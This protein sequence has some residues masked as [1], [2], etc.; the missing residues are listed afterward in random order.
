MYTPSV[1]KLI[2]QICKLP[3]IGEKTAERL[4]FYMLVEPQQALRLSEA[5]AQMVHQTRH[6]KVCYHFAEEELC[7]IC[8]D[9]T[10]DKSLICV[11]EEPKDVISVERSGGYRGLYHVLLGRFAPLEGK[12][13]ED[14]TINALRQ[15][16][17]NNPQIQEV[18]LATN[19]NLEGDG[20][21][22]YVAQMLQD[23]SVKITRIARGISWGLTLTH[24][25]KASMKDAFLGRRELSLTEKENHNLPKK[26]KK[27]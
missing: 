13:P 26:L 14:L 5:I 22:L 6:C 7:E 10:R 8:Q 2:E 18:I 15:R 24:A 20:T 21:A 25:N 4:A 27:K 1:N 19:P 11:V 12:K 16:L 23:M 17:K 3:G 9:E